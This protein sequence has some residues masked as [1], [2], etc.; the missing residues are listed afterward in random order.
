M[1]R[2]ISRIRDLPS[3]FFPLSLLVLLFQLS[4]HHCFVDGFRDDVLI[5]FPMLLMIN[6][7]IYMCMQENFYLVDENKKRRNVNRPLANRKRKELLIFST[8]ETKKTNQTNQCLSSNHVVFF[9]N[10]F[11]SYF[12]T[13]KINRVIVFHLHSVKFFVERK[14]STSQ[15]DLVNRSIHINICSS[16]SVSDF[17]LTN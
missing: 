8:R 1:Y 13:L 14:A 4:E 15:L 10:R 12:E 3:F 2:R 16:R 9:A 7:K 11:G 5:S 6:Y 17:S